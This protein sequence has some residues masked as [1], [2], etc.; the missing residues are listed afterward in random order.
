MMSANP[1][2]SNNETVEAACLGT[3]LHDILV[4]HKIQ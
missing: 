4:L 1:Q 2:Y 3:H